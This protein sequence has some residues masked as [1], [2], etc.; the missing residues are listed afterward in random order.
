MD[1]RLFFLILQTY[2]TY[3]IRILYIATVLL[4]CALCCVC[5]NLSMNW[6]RHLHF[7]HSMIFFFPHYLAF[8]QFPCP[9]T[10]ILL[11][12]IT[13]LVVFLRFVSQLHVIDSSPV[14]FLVVSLCRSLLITVNNNCTPCI[15][16][17]PSKSHL[18]S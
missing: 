15:I 17:V 8:C 2:G 3:S 14:V 7:H 18:V 6:C 9:S 1:C 11:L 4:Y 16:A 12:Q 13:I 5:H 10:Q